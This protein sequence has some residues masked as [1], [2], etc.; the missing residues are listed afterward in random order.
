MAAARVCSL[1]ELL[2]LVLFEL[3]TRDLLLAQRVCQTW[4][5]VI[6]GSPKLQRA[7]YFEPVA[8]DQT[9]MHEKG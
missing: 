5:A 6:S 2:E 1:P 7:L 3:P 8:G 9:G 4:Q